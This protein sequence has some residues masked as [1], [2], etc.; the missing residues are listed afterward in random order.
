MGK[1]EPLKMAGRLSATLSNRRGVRSTRRH[2]HRHQLLHHRHPRQLTALTGNQVVQGQF[3]QQLA[4]QGALDPNLTSVNGLTKRSGCES[5]SYVSDKTHAMKTNVSIS[6]VSIGGCMAL[7]NIGPSGLWNRFKDDWLITRQAARLFFVSTI[8]VLALTPVFLGRVVTTNMP[9]WMRVP[10]GILGIVGPLALF[11]LW[12]GMWR[13]WVRVDDSKAYAK[14]L[15]FLI[16]LLGFWYG[17]CLY[18]YFVYLPQVM[19][20]SRS[21]A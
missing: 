12:I 20:R 1:W 11:F 14:R 8:L 7:E 16:L 13:Y 9:L 17:S 19:R 21:Q 2:R 6:G 5:R 18:C 3:H 15:W 4:A 10:W